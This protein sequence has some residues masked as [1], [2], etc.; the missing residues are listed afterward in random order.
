VEDVIVAPDAIVSLASHEWERLPLAAEAA[1][2]NPSSLV[3]LT[4]PAVVTEYNCHDCAGRIAR[5]ESLGVSRSRIRTAPLTLPGTYGEAVASGALLN[6]AGARRV[7]VVTS[8]YHTRRT[9]AVFRAVLG[10]RMAVGVAPATATSPAHPQTWWTS[11]YDRWYVTYEWA[12]IVYYAVRY[13][14][15]S[16]F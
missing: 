2:K 15:V 4:Q 1:H 11:P 13:R 7:L 6:K 14:I 10:S 12:A 8:P 3:V 5:L 16:F 9:R